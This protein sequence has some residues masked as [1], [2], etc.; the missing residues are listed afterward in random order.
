[1]RTKAP[2]PSCKRLRLPES[3]L[4]AVSVLLVSKASVPDPLTPPDPSVPAAP[5]DPT[6]SVVL[7][8]TVVV[9]VYVLLPVRTTVPPPIVPDCVSDPLPEIALAM[10]APVASS[11]V[12]AALSVTAPEPSVPVVA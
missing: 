7:E 1:M 8:L 11:N 4:P 9:P 10:V 12:S 6:W 2:E 3:V 5:P